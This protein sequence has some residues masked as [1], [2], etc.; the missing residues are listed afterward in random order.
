MSSN[1]RKGVL[2]L[3]LLTALTSLTAEGSDWGLIERKTTSEAL[4]S[5]IGRWIDAVLGAG[6]QAIRL[7]KSLMTTWES[8]PIGESIDHSIETFATAFDT[9]EPRRLMQAFLDRRRS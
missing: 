9:D 5:T 2:T 6:P 3:A 4:D 1:A 7:Q 8:K